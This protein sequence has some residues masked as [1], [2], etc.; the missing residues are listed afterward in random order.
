MEKYMYTETRLYNDA[1][2]VLIVDSDSAAVQ[3]EFT[4]LDGSHPSG[5]YYILQHELPVIIDALTSA[6]NSINKK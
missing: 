1:D 6:M 5:K 2:Q 4:E 3:I